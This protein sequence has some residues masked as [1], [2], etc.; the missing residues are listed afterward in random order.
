M[1]RPGL[2]AQRHAGA[3]GLAGPAATRLCTQSPGH[4]PGHRFSRSP[5]GA[6]LP[7]PRREPVP[8]QHVWA[9]PRATDLARARSERLGVTQYPS[10]AN[11]QVALAAAVAARAA[12]LSQLEVPGHS[13]QV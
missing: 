10:R 3:S 11:V 4:P 5:L 13:V 1:T 8:P 2:V 7:V 6:A 9:G 12:R